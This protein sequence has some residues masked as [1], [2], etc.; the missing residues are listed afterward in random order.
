MDDWAQQVHFSAKS[1]SN[2]TNVYERVNSLW[3]V[4]L[5]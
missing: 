2:A 3:R 4:D 5:W 1:D